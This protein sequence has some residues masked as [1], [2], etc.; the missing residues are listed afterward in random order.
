MFTLKRGC[1]GEKMFMDIISKTLNYLANQASAVAG[2]CTL[3]TVMADVIDLALSTDQ[4]I[5]VAFVLMISKSQ[6]H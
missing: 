5:L 4:E 6:P 1:V 2:H 3:N